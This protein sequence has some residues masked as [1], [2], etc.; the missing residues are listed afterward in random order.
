MEVGAEV[1]AIGGLLAWRPTI[2]SQQFPLWRAGNQYSVIG[3]HGDIDLLEFSYTDVY[4][5]PQ[6]VFTMDLLDMKT[7][8][9]IQSNYANIEYGDNFTIENTNDAILDGWRK[10]LVQIGSFVIPA[11]EWTY[12]LKAARP[13][14]EMNRYEEGQLII[15]YSDPNLRLAFSTE[16]MQRVV[17]YKYDQVGGYG[18]H[19][20]LNSE[21]EPWQ[22]AFYDFPGKDI[23][24]DL[25]VFKRYGYKRLGW[26]DMNATNESEAALVQESCP[27]RYRRA[28][29]TTWRFGRRYRWNTG[30]G[31]TIRAWTAATPPRSRPSITATAALM[32]PSPPTRP[33]ASPLPRPWRP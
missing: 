19:F 23:E 12:L 31:T 25:D 15:T 1:E 10:N 18:Q 7:G 2:Y 32:R 4:N 21:A 14:E 30:C 33:P 17:N 26:L 3:F 27:V 5:V 8:E 20:Q 28:A 13:V 9:V 24:Y 16:P 29:S 6:S 22:L 11:I